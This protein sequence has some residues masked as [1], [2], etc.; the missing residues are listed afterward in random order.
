MTEK[1]DYQNKLILNKLSIFINECADAITKDMVEKTARDCFC[2]NDKA[3]KI[4]LS[5]ALDVFENKELMRIY[6]DHP[7]MLKMLCAD[8]YQNDAYYTEITFNSVVKKGGWELKMSQYAPYELF[9]ANDLLKLCDGRIIPRLG[10][11]EKPF[12]FPCI[13]QNGRE[14]MTVT[15]NEI[16][17][18]KK[19]ISDAKGKVLTYG[20]GLGY[21]A[22]MTSRKE[23]VSS[24]TVIEND[25]SVIELFENCIL[26]QFAQ[27]DKINI[28]NTDAL[29]FAAEQKTKKTSDF[30]FVFSD[31]W[32]DASDGAEI[33]KLFKTLE[34][35]D[36]TYAYWIEDT[37]KCYL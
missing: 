31:I 18:M 26:P 2:T 10:Y 17:T 6:F 23:D 25:K 11:F 5:G 22:F 30:D 8:Q 21:F 14:W 35:N 36:T 1:T 27:K 13:L 28:I 16:E 20:L 32:H 3:Y 19:P 12:S 15:P 24:V 29:F 37:I 4:L 33:Y 7:E 9:V 34:R